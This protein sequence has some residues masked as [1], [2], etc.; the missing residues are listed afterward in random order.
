MGASVS[1]ILQRLP[2]ALILGVKTVRISIVFTVFGSKID[3]KW[4]GG[5]L[6][7]EHQVPL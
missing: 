2:N 3:V 6:T 1:S 4:A 5:A 7:T